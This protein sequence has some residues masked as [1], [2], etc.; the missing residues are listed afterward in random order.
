MNVLAWLFEEK[1]GME[2]RGEA[3]LD[4]VLIARIRG[5]PTPELE[6]PKLISIT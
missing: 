5:T 1:E 2:K 4:I 6:V 3:W